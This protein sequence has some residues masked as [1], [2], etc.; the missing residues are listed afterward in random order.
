MHD[1]IETLGRFLFGYYLIRIKLFESIGSKKKL[2]VKV[3]LISLPLAFSYIV[4]KWLAITGAMDL[5]AVYW[6][7]FIKIG[8]FSTA[9]F[10]SS[11]LVLAFIS[12]ERNI[13]FKTFQALG[14]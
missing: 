13:V 4:V 10:Y 11:M 12:R 6:E 14:K 5:T 8:I 3:L 1:I 7:P 9:C 2:F